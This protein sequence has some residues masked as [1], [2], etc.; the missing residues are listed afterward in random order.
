MTASQIN[1]LSTDHLNVLDV[2][3]ARYRPGGRPEHDGDRQPDHYAGGG[4]AGRE[5]AALDA[6]Q[7]GQLTTTELQN[8]STT[9]ADALTAAQIGR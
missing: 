2:T 8:L 3:A 5:V 1:A 6:S 7:I 9:Q 4:A